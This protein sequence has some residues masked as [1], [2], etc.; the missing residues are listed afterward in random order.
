MLANKMHTG[1]QSP[2]RYALA[3]RI[4]QIHHVCRA[5]SPGKC[6]YHALVQ[7]TCGKS[8][9]YRPRKLSSHE[10]ATDIARYEFIFTGYRHAHT[11]WDA[12]W[13]LF[14][15]HTETVRVVTTKNSSRSLLYN[16]NKWNYLAAE[17]V[18]A[19]PWLSALC[20]LGTHHP[21]RYVLA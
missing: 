10:E 17:C 9:V 11:E 8:E 13:S 6:K 16:P 19:H 5:I 3:C 1:V 4:L 18:D 15:W 21:V 7:E 12:V 14:E 20:H 2:L